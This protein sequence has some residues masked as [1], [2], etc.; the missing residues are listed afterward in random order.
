MKRGWIDSLNATLLLFS[1]WFMEPVMIQ[2]LNGKLKWL[3]LQACRGSL[4]DLDVQFD[5]NEEMKIY[6]KHFLISYCTG[7]GTVSYQFNDNGKVYIQSICKQLCKNAEAENYDRCLI[8]MLQ[9]VGKEVEQS[10]DDC[11][12]SAYSRPEF[13]TNIDSYKF[14]I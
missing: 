14:R 12:K 7:E 9:D 13:H 3:V 2:Q 5:N 4:N 11:G 1:V 8:K 10:G 6:V